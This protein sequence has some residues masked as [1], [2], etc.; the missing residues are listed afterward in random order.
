M[1]IASP[2]KRA[3]GSKLLTHVTD[4]VFGTM[5]AEIL[6]SVVVSS[7]VRG[8]RSDAALLPGEEPVVASASERRRRAFHHR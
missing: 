4:C 3:S 5:I 2:Q 8:D 1:L 7:E 6:P